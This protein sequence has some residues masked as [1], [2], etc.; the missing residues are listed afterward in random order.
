MRVWRVLPLSLLLLAC[1]ALPEH[2]VLLPSGE[3]VEFAMDTPNENEYAL[4]SAL[5]ATAQGGDA[6]DAEQSARNDLRNKA[7]ALGA[8]LVLIDSNHAS[9]IML[10]KKA[11]VVIKARAYKA[12]D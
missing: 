7:A 4:V 6:A 3:Q 12:R 9:P 11:K 8:S 5:E 2:V 1:E 10:Q